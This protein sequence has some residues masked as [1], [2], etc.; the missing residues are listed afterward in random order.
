LRGANIG[1]NCLF[2]V[3]RERRVV[4]PLVW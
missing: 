4:T 1:V 2:I 3:G